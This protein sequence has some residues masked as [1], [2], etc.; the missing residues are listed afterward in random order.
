MSLN[1]LCVEV[2]APFTFSQ[3][4]YR[5]FHFEF[6]S[7]YT[8]CSLLM[9]Q[10]W[11]DSG[12][13]DLD[14]AAPLQ[15]PEDIST[16]WGTIPTPGNTKPDGPRLE[17]I[18]CVCTFLTRARAL[19]RGSSSSCSSASGILG[20]QAVTVKIASGTGYIHLLANFALLPVR[21]KGSSQ[22]DSVT[23][24]FQCRRWG[25][26]IERPGQTRFR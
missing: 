14:G 9:L 22:S 2:Q 6:T 13:Q 5:P 15:S 20:T 25:I 10:A 17:C 23:P 16:A 12:F 21:L 4:H 18:E 24:S 3:N 1:H 8:F 19:C 7:I 11:L 26:C